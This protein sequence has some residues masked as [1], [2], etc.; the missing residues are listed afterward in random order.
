MGEER[1]QYNFF[2]L[3]KNNVLVFL[4]LYIY[5]IYIYFLL[6]AACVIISLVL[7]WQLTEFVKTFPRI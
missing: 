6:R 3:N 7:M 2:F 1:T 4:V 5:N